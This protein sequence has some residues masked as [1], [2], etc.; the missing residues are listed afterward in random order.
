MDG[1]LI[2]EVSLHPSDSADKGMTRTSDAVSTVVGEDGSV[3]AA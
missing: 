2:G 3:I 1:K